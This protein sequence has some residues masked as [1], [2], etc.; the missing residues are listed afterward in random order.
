MEGVGSATTKLVRFS[1]TVRIGDL[2]AAAAILVSGIGI[3]NSLDETR[4]LT[5]IELDNHRREAAGRAIAGLD[6]WIA[7][8]HSLR[9]DLQPI[10]IS[11][12]ETL[13]DT[14][15]E[16]RARDQ[17]WREVI[18]AYAAV[19]RRVA[20]EQLS[21]GYE[22]LLIYSPGSRRIYLET[23]ASLREAARRNVWAIVEEG[24]EAIFSLNEE[25][26]PHSA[27]L[28]NA[29][30]AIVIRHFENLE[31]RS[32]E[33]SIRARLHFCSIVAERG[34]DAQTCASSTVETGH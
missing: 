22:S 3:F 8:Q 5:E 20:T 23:Y 21:T 28:G 25:D 26:R 30:R 14:R 34:E 27:I 18:A 29:L 6:R 12:S 4:Q 19:E 24:Q 9:S 7:L 10:I 15:D 32:Y 33:L 13:R 11:V 31:R 16:A 17:L 2:V 1:G